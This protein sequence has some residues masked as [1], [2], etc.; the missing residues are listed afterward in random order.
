VKSPAGMKNRNGS[1]QSLLVL[2]LGGM[3]VY[4]AMKLVIPY[5]AYKDLERTMSYWGKIALLRGDKNYSELKDKIE[6]VIDEHDI[7]LEIDEVQIE[8]DQ[9]QETLTVSA[10]Y[11]VLVEFPGYEYRFHFEP[12][13]EVA[14]DE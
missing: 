8:R 1:A 4:A 5:Y 9:V 13:A 10:E 7:P 3:C 6:W 11:D 12:Y 14:A 2:F